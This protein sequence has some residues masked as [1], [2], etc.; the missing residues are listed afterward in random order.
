MASNL[1]FKCVEILY[2]GMLLV[3]VVLMQSSGPECDSV[4]FGG[5]D[6]S[7]HRRQIRSVLFRP[8]KHKVVEEGN[9]D[10]KEFHVC[11]L[12]PEADTRTCMSDGER[13]FQL[14]TPSCDVTSE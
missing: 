9:Q 14:S 6:A 10:Q 8:H 4:G 3:W 12:F 1:S 13:E 11:Q 5:L 7:K 2:E